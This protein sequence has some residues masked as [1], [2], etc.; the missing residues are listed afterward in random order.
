MGLIK[1]YG[2]I[3]QQGIKKVLRATNLGNTLYILNSGQK[4][5]EFGADYNDLSDIVNIEFKRELET[6]TEYYGDTLISFPEIV[7]ATEQEL[8]GIVSD[9]EIGIPLTKI[10]PL[11]EIDHILYL[12]EYLEKGIMSISEKGWNLEDL[13]EENILINLNSQDKPVRI[14]DTDF[15]CL[16]KER[17][18]LELY[19][20]NMKKVFLSIIYGIIPRLSSSNIWQDE[21]VREK[22]NLAVNGSIKSSEF[23]KFLLMKIKFNYQRTKNVQTLRKSL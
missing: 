15:Y 7:I 23:M 17:D 3:E 20:Q 1:N 14:I 16:Q 18:K 5:K 9:F 19:R 12:I 11:T 6:Q 2:Y 8:L 10:N 22:Y 4:Y 21:E 13:H